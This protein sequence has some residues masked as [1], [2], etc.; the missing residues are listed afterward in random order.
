MRELL[1]R[2]AIAESELPVFLTSWVDKA[3]PLC[4][5]TMTH[6]RQWS[7]AHL[8]AGCWYIDCSK[9]YCPVEEEDT[10]RACSQGDSKG[11]PSNEVQAEEEEDVAEVDINLLPARERV[12]LLAQRARE[13]KAK[14]KEEKKTKEKEEKEAEKTKEKEKKGKKGEKKKP[15]TP[16]VDLALASVATP[17]QINRKRD[18][19]AAE[20]SL[21]RLEQVA[22]PALMDYG[23]GA[24]GF[25]ELVISTSLVSID[26]HYVEHKA[27]PKVWT[28]IKAFL[29]KVIL[30][31]C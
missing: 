19:T 27:L 12:K 20:L 25:H 16:P 30:I 4:M 28:D 21:S 10:K 2:G 23:V 26:A 7:I 24:L 8:K 9:M 14:E 15:P 6:V 11:G 22:S 17:S 1:P 3:S 13:K 18:A 29:Q 31:S 5:Y